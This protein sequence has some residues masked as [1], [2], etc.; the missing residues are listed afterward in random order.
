MPRFFAVCPRGIEDTLG[1]ELID[2]RVEQVKVQSGGV[3]FS[4]PMRAAY[5]ANL[6][7]R[8]ASRI[9]WL[10]A[11]GE[12]R[13]EDD[14]YRLANDIPWEKDFS[15]QQTLRVDVTAHK[16]PLQSLQFAALRVKDAICDRFRETQGERPSID[17]N[18][19]DV[20]ALVHLTETRAHVYVDLSGESLFK[21]GWR[22]DKGEAPIK[23]NL[24]A[25]LIRLAGW[26]STEP[27]LDPF[28]G[29]GTLL[30]EAACAATGRAPGLNRRFA[31]ERLKSHDAA[32]WQQLK[33]E[34]RQAIRDD[35][36]LSL[37]GRDISTRVIETAKSNALRAGLG[38]LLV[39]GRL[40]FEAQDARQ[41][42]PVAQTG[43]I[44]SNP[45]YGEQ[46]TPRSASV[47]D[48]MRDFA[49]QLKQQ[50]SGWQVW[51]ISSDLDLP[52]QMRLKESAKKVC[53][54][55][56]LECRFFCFRMVAGS[57][58]TTRVS[59]DNNTAA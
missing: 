8:T 17:R 32:L 1:A 6:H 33:D 42:G 21:R 23:E 35:L 10:K 58:R 36:P 38:K 3:M 54:N 28:C 4:G 34:A 16:S 19:P 43:W 50:F 51:M 55:G 24:A 29:S 49:T 14:I 37:T 46:S 7:L 18:R 15:Y 45:P 2:L 25:A 44:I 27:L 53:F 30:I 48:L 9:L 41:G 26:K 12:Y 59:T 57:N 47:P 52:R 31:F 11:E 40:R 39:D 5:L 13:D 56:P 20:Q 22:M